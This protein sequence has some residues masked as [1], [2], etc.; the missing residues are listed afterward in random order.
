MPDLSDSPSERRFVDLA[1]RP[2]EDNAELL[3]AARDD[4]TSGLPANPHATLRHRHSRASRDVFRVDSDSP[5]ISPR[6]G[7][8][9]QRFPACSSPFTVPMKS[10]GL[11]ATG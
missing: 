6:M 9:N 11:G 3:D 4:L 5:S 7:Y 8:E 10:S 1:T 2:L